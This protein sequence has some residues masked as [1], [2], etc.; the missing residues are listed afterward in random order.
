[1][2]AKRTGN[3]MRERRSSMVA[4]PAEKIC[5][6]PS[7]S[8]G[9]SAIFAGAGGD[10]LGQRH[11]A[12]RVTRARGEFANRSE[13]FAVAQ[14]QI[15][16]VAIE[17][18]HFDR[19]GAGCR[20]AFPSR[21]GEDRFRAFAAHRADDMQRPRRALIKAALDRERALVGVVGKLDMHARGRVGQDER[22]ADFEILDDERRG[23]QTTA[24]PL[25]GPGPRSPPPGR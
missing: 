17:A 13:F 24:R 21:R 3:F 11:A 4:A 12:R 1:M 6:A 16:H 10:D 22:F 5:S 15:A 20:R 8:T 23:L 18:F 25:R 9:C 2:R 7:K 19:L 14:P